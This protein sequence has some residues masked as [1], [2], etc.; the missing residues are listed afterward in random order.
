HIKSTLVG[1][2][3]MVIVEKG[4]MLLGTWQSIYFC[5]FDGPRNRKVFVKIIPA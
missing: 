4:K 5:E 1:C 2:S 3:Q